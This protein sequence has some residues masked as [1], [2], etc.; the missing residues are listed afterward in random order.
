[1]IVLKARQLGVSTYVAARLYH[2]TI[3]SPGLRTIIIGHE[4]RASRNLFAMVKRFHDNLP[5]DL[6]PS[7]GYVECR[8]TGFRQDRQRLSG[9]CSHALKAPAD[10]LPRKL[11]HCSETA[12]WPDLPKRSWPHLLQTVPDARRHGN[13]F[14]KHGIRLQ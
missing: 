12:F 5:D 11:L 14:G 4:R 13:H 9:L 1:M 10:R 6:R 3:N 2:T 8:R 7:Y